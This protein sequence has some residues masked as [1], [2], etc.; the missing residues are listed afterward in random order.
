MYPIIGLDT[1]S[2]LQEFEV[3]RRFRQLAHEGGKVVRTKD[4]TF[5][6]PGD[7]PGINLW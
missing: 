1:P 2:G 7:I 4:R 5:L 6:L 3:P